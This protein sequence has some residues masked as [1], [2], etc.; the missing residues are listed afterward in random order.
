MENKMENNCFYFI[1]TSVV[2]VKQYSI[3]TPEERYEQTKITIQ[4]I[5]KFVKSA[6]IIVLECCE[7][8]VF[9][10]VRMFY[11]KPP[12]LFYTHK[13]NGEAFYLKT[14]LTSETFP[15]DAFFFKISG[16]YF[17]NEHF[18]IELFDK[19]NFNARQ[20]DH[21]DGKCCVT[22][23]FGF[24]CNKI[25]ILISQ[26]D[27]IDNYNDNIEHTLFKGIPFNNISFLGISGYLARSGMFIVY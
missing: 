10:D 15:P 13:S 17:L 23:L 6:K 18:N 16:R 7:D 11:I 12:E 26:L 9:D 5:K 22:S 4:S 2:N 8:I 14:F 24:P 19:N 25:D 21:G 27:K 3:Y 20:V 1:I